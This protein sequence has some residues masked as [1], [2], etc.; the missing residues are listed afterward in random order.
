MSKVLTKHEQLEF[1]NLI[2]ETKGLSLS[3]KQ[4]RMTLM[5]GQEE[6]L[7]LIATAQKEGLS[8]GNAALRM[9][10]K[11]AQKNPIEDKK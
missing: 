2:K 3:G 1:E 11:Y 9:I 4:A 10:Q 7:Y 8:L 5:M 6:T